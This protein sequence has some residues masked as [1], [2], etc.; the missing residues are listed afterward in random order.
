MNAPI[1]IFDSGIGGL[2]V[3]RHIHTQLPQESL[4]YFADQ[5]HVPYGSR[6]RAE[7]QQFSQAITQFLI[8]QG[9]KLIV[10]ACNTATAAALPQLRQHFPDVPFVGMEP[11]VKPAAQQTQNGKVGVLAT[12]STFASERYADLMY[13]FAHNITVWEDPCHGLVPLIEAGADCSPR[14][15]EILHP[16]LAQEIDTLVLGC[17]H[18]PFI[19]PEIN[20]IC[21]TA[22]TLIDPAPAVARRT[23]QLLEQHQIQATGTQPAAPITLITSGK[24]PQFVLQA[25]RLLSLDFLPKT[26]VWSSPYPPAILKILQQT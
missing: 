21:G 2:S 1:G 16:M 18:Y 7:I 26:A 22:V 15:T 17:T 5:A 14:L 13:R 9:A 10:V 8:D 3:L 12:A 20:A 19:V 6:T 25:R 11:A 23:Q 4:L 24:L